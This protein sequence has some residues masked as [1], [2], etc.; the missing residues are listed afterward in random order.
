MKAIWTRLPLSMSV[1]LPRRLAKA[2]KE[3][4]FPSRCLS[5]GAFFVPPSLA[6]RSA[7]PA[8][9]M[10]D[11][12]LFAKAT[13]AVVCQECGLRFIPV[14]SPLCSVCGI[15]FK[16][17]EGPDH[18]CQQCLQNEK[19]YDSARACGIYDETLRALIHWFKY[20][21]FPQLAGPLGKVMNWG[22]GRHFGGHKIDLLIPVP[23]HRRRFRKRGFNQAYLLAR[24]GLMPKNGGHHR[25]SDKRL[26][27]SLL[28]RSRATLPQTGLGRQER[29]RNMRRAFAIT[30]TQSI[31]GK[32]ILLVDDVFTTG[33]T[34]NECAKV[35]KQAGAMRVDVLTL[36]R[37]LQALR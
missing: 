32:N 29:A 33:A 19:F 36:A 6:G 7:A 8:D 27:H 17:R 13:A 1:S 25:P 35:L 31:A 10:K 12:N 15:P 9:R 2:L 14:F 30:E 4:I 16:S 5:C 23:L 11:G 37:A 24:H 18:H 28:L 20:K 22:F 3:A 21:N 26:L 34:V